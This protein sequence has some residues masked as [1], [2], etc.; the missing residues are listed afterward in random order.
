MKNSTAHIRV[1]SKAILYSE[2]QTNNIETIEPKYWE[3]DISNRQMQ[4]NGII[5]VLLLYFAWPIHI[6]MHTHP[7]ELN[8]FN[9]NATREYR[10][11]IN[12]FLLTFMV[13][14]LHHSH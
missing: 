13:K 2:Q 4:N 14:W 3:T 8:P 6:Q 11:R 12:S 9:P 7:S 10:K 1:K 5:D